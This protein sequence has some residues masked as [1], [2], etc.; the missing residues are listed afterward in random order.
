MSRLDE[1]I[2]KFA[3]KQDDTEEQERTKRL[4]KDGK[5]KKVWSR[6]ITCCFQGAGV[7]LFIYLFGCVHDR[8]FDQHMK[9]P[10]WGDSIM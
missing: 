1:V 3:V 7:F 6:K 2:T 5:D 10:Q 9:A 8:T 4:E